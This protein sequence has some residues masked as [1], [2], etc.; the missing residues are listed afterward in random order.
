M[1]EDTRN[2]P[3]LFIC[4]YLLLVGLFAACAS[5][6]TLPLTEEGALRAV[7]AV[8]GIVGLLFAAYGALFLWMRSGSSC[9]VGKVTFTLIGVGL[10]SF[11]SGPLF[12]TEYNAVLTFGGLVVIMCG[13]LTPRFTQLCESMRGHTTIG[14]LILIATL[15]SAC[16][17]G[18]RAGGP[19]YQ[20]PEVGSPAAAPMNTPLPDM[21]LHQKVF[22]KIVVQVDEE[23]RVVKVSR[24]EKL[25][26]GAIEYAELAFPLQSLTIVDTFIE[27]PSGPKYP[28]EGCNG[29]VSREEI[30]V[31]IWC[32]GHPGPFLEIGNEL[33]LNQALQ[34]GPIPS[35]EEIP[36]TD[37]WDPLGT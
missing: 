25:W 7:V 17:E 33:L 1:K 19:G 16:G 32:A 26:F 10:V 23:Q 2:S 37:S 14:A 36:A 27:F 29:W 5:A 31:E 24:L 9:S 28:S 30:F 8:L 15:V 4:L 22:S 11:I 6:N 35:P 3:S 18:S 20:E 13:L 12:S 21:L 34:R